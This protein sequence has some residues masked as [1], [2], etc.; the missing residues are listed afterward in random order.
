MEA[1]QA[2]GKET[3]TKIDEKGFVPDEVR[4]TFFRKL[5]MKSENRSCFECPNRNPTWI[6]LTYG[7]YLCL[8]CSGEHRRKGVHIS[9]VRSVELDSF[10]P[11]Q[12]VQMACGGNG[13]AL[14]FF[15]SNEMGKLSG[16]GR[17]VDYTSKSAQRYKSQL[18]TDCKTICQ[19]LALP[20]KGAQA[21]SKT[22]DPVDEA[23]DFSFEPSGPAVKAGYASAT[24]AVKAM[25]SGYP[26]MPELHRGASAPAAVTPSPK[27]AS[28]PASIVIRKMEPPAAS[29]AAPKASGFGGTTSKAKEIDFDFDFDDLEAE[30]SKPKPA[31][32]PAPAPVPVK[33]EVA[34]PPS[35]QSMARAQSDSAA[36]GSKFSNKKGIS[37]DDFFEEL[38]GESAQARVDRDNRFQKFAGAG[39]ISSASYFGNDESDNREDWSARSSIK[40]GANMIS[41]YLAKVRD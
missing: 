15:K 35:A 11:E 38:E 9:F 22:A 33:K 1:L 23:A 14:D 29:A 12:M 39:A 4:N 36:V 34:P 6:S 18:E 41:E 21:S 31:P 17:P 19:Q 26:A 30:A 24:P 2:I 20:S 13:K 37:S 3:L 40:D 16:S 10:A 32:A 5:R 27:P 25:D 8:E 28:S 7:I